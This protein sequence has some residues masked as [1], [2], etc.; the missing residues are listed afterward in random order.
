ML[1][2][3]EIRPPVPVEREDEEMAHPLESAYN[4]RLPV[5]VSS[6]GLVLCIGL[7]ARS[8]TVGW[9]SAAIVLALC[10]V[11]FM[12]VVWLRTQAYLMVD[13]D[14]LTVRSFRTMHEIKG[15]DV[16]KVIQVLTPSGPSYRLVVR[17]ADGTVQRYGAQ[18]ALLRRAHSTLFRWI[19]TWA[20]QAELD[21]GS[22]RTLQTL[23]ERGAL[24]YP[25][26][27]PDEKPDHHVQQ[28]RDR[29]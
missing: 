5:S 8:Q 11:A 23:R 9:L 19:L 29:R 27:E 21:K 15:A 3:I 25:D 4:W 14:T 7:L 2:T 10:W 22:R 28:P 6:V 17:T 1:C 16:V 26:D 13:G 12:G 20:P 18:T 24:P